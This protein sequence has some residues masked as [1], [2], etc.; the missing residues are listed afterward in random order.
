LKPD[1]AGVSVASIR[2]DLRSAVTISQ[3]ISLAA[4]KAP[5]PFAKNW[6]ELSPSSAPKKQKTDVVEH[7]EGLDHVG[8][9][10]DELPGPAGLPFI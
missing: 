10:V 9:L 7:P 8:L 3:P 1:Q 5:V 4:C 2:Y 6:L